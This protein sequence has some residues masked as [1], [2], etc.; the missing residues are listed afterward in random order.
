MTLLTNIN[1]FA[2][3]IMAKSTNA[4]KKINISKT[5]LKNTRNKISCSGMDHQTTNHQEHI[6]PERRHIVHSCLEKDALSSGKE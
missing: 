4:T 3:E 6:V 2:I 1:L 5:A